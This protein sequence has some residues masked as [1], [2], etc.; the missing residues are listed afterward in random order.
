MDGKELFIIIL[1]IAILASVI[2]LVSFKHSNS[3]ARLIRIIFFILVIV[4]LLYILYEVYEYFKK[5]K[6]NEPLLL[7]GSHDASKSFSFSAKELPKS[8]VGAEYT[9]SFWMYVNSWNYRYDSAKHVLS[10]GSYP[11]SNTIEPMVFNPGVW[12]YPKTSNLYIRF[13]TYG[14]P[15]N[16]EYFP[17]QELLGEQLNNDSSKSEGN[18]IDDTTVEGC[19]K[20]CLLTDGCGGIV[21]NTRSGRCFMKSGQDVQPKMD[22]PCN[23][24]KE[25]TQYKG[26][27][28]AGIGDQQFICKGGKPGIEDKKNNKPKWGNCES[29]FDSYVKTDSMN[30]NTSNLSHLDPNDQCDIM[31]LPLQRWVHVGIVLWNR[32]TDIYLNGKLVRSCI[33]PN[34]PRIPW[35]EPLYVCQDGGFDGSIATL[36][37]FNRSLNATEMYKLYAKGPLQWSILREFEDLFPKVTLSGSVS[38]DA[39]KGQHHKHH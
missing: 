4:I 20:A 29:V 39:S 15:P 21:I 30:P 13:D 22:Q 27:G 36:R 33:L 9:Y 32:T 6:N 31:E 5:I 34:V 16:F 12:F 19:K 28:D 25:C 8:S 18:S 37:Y 14:R 26:K 35:D 10:R 23:S 2:A 3:A 7:Y 1:V 17:G 38:Y 11:K 24:D